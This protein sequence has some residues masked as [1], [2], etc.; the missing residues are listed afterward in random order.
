MTL[1]GLQASASQITKCS[2]WTLVLHP[3]CASEPPVDGRA[4]LWN[5][6]LIGL[7]WGLSIGVLRCF[8]NDSHMQPGLNHRLGDL[9]GPSSKNNTTPA[10]DSQARGTDGGTGWAGA[11]TAVLGSLISA[12]LQQDPLP[13]Q[14]CPRFVMARAVQAVRVHSCAPG[15]RPRDTGPCSL[16]RLWAGSCGWGGGSQLSGGLA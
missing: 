7:E 13:G 12:R 3:A 6:D 11:T 9:E 4:P 10:A 8:L 1:P 5:S 16:L 15:R 14:P 2:I